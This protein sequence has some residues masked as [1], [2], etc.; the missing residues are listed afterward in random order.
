MES[1]LIH[2]ES[3]EQ[4]KTVKAVLKALKV[5]FESST[6]TFPPHVSESISRGMQQYEAGKSITLEEFTQKHLSEQ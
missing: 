6:V 1:I 4:L 2:P 3:A 5:Q